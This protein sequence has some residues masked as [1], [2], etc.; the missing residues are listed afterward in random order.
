MK[1][2]KYKTNVE[3]PQQAM[4]LIKTLQLRISDCLLSFDQDSYHLS[5]TTTREVSELVCEL[6]VKQGFVC[7]KVKIRS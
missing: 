5:V 3:N 2:E 4:L 7:K 1:V 6:F